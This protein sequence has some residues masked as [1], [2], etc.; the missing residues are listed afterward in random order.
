MEQGVNLPCGLATIYTT[1]LPSMFTRGRFPCPMVQ[2]MSCFWAK[3]ASPMLHD[4][5]DMRT[6]NTWNL[7]TW[8]VPFCTSRAHF[9]PLHPQIIRAV[10]PYDCQRSKKYL[11]LFWVRKKKNA[12]PYLQWLLLLELSIFASNKV[13]QHTW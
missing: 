9:F 3:P 1:P 8:P 13:L 12:V 10:F 11:G 2:R 4:H 6:L 7:S 5:M